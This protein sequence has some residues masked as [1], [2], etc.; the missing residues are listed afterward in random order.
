MGVC[1]CTTSSLSESLNGT[2]RSWN[3]Q[4]HRNMH[5][6]LG[7]S[8]W[9]VKCSIK[10]DIN[11][12]RWNGCGCQPRESAGIL[13]TGKM[14]AF[15]TLQRN[16]GIWTTLREA[17]KNAGILVFDQFAKENMNRFC[18][19]FGAIY[20]QFVTIYQNLFVRW[21]IIKNKSKLLNKSSSIKIILE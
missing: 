19:N 20:T 18:S 12:R 2:T 15:C 6:T 9:E 16:S 17:G 13:L 8:R 3:A 1:T 14:S 10:C 4:L 11:A 7:Y 5:F 21:R